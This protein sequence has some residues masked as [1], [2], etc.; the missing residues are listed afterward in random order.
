MSLPAAT[1]FIEID[2]QLQPVVP[3]GDI[4]KVSLAEVSLASLDNAPTI[5]DEVVAGKEGGDSAD[6]D[7]VGDD[8]VIADEAVL[9]VDEVEDALRD[10]F[11]EADQ[12][13]SITPDQDGASSVGENLTLVSPE[14]SPDRIGIRN[15]SAYRGAS[16]EHGSKARPERH[17]PR[18]PCRRGIA[19]W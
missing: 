12:S 10:A 16:R 11:A 17:S 19:S 8:T 18:N 3:I 7:P 2:H 4:T 1:T 6:E 9:T 13:V 15:H 5:S 14:S